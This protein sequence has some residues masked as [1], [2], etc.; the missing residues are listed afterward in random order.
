MILK[1]ITL[2]VDNRLW[3]DR[4]EGRQ[5]PVRLILDER[6]SC[7]EQSGSN[8]G[9]GEKWIDFEY[10]LEFKQTGLSWW[11]RCGECGKERNQGWLL[12]I[13]TAKT[14]IGEARMKSRF[15]GGKLRILF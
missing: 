5:E 14:E 8:S 6:R 10:I 15:K 4:M 3:E 1:K 7:L 12:D 13:L 9:N 11:I 2:D